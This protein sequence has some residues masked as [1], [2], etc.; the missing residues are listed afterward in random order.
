MNKK[1]R[2]IIQIAILVVFISLIFG[3]LFF[4][5][6]PTS[7]TGLIIYDLNPDVEMVIPD[8]D[9]YDQYGYATGHQELTKRQDG[10][11]DIALSSS[12]GIPELVHVDEFPEASIYINGYDSENAS[13]EI[14]SLIDTVDVDDE[15]YENFKTSVFAID[16]IEINN[17]IITLPKTSNVEYIMIC[18]DFDQENFECIDGAG[19]QETGKPC[20]GPRTQKTALR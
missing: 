8:V 3:F 17:A 12:P 19:W 5:D 16:S 11:F 9:L 6:Q 15:E 1:Q 13:V 10:K 18:D 20:D 14:K 7:A 4:T 2:Q